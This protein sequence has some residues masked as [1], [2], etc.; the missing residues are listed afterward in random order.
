MP[1]FRAETLIYRSQA[2]RIERS[3]KVGEGVE[4]RFNRGSMSTF[5]V[6]V[7]KQYSATLG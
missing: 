7:L 5:I 2:D 4:T 6:R 1:A 3:G